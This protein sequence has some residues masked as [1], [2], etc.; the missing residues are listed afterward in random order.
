[1]T[2]SRRNFFKQVAAASGGA[3]LAELLASV[4]RASAI[5]PQPDSTYLDA[6]HVVILMQE[7]RS[8][9]HCFG[10]LRGVR[11]FNDPRAVKLPD[12]KP[13]W[14]QSNQAG[15]TYAPFRLN[16]KETKATWLGSL[17][18]SWSDQTDA[19]NHGN[20]D[21]W[22]D[23][24]V[25]GRREC[26]GMPFTMGYYER[27]D[28]PFYY[29]FADAFTIC[30]QHFCS[31][32][33]GTTPNRL[34][35]WTGTVREK[36]GATPCVRNSEADYGAPVRWKTFPERLEDAGVSWKIYQNELSVETGLNKEQEVWLANYTDNPIE[37]FEQFHVN[38]AENHR[39]ELEH[40][41]ATLPAEIE[42]MRKSV[43]AL[44]PG[45][46]D[47]RVRSRDLA[48][49]E[50][51][52]RNAIE[53]RAKWTPKA[54]AALTPADWSLHRKAFTTN[55]GDPSYRELEPL[56]YRDGNATRE[57]L[58]PKG[59]VLHQFRT[60]VEKG[61]LPTVSWL[62][63]P[64]N[65]SD[66]PAAPWYGAWYVAEA[67]DILTRNPEVW[68]KTI[69]ILTYDENDGY[70]DHVP[71]FV[72]PDPNNGE[73]GKTSPGMGAE[74]DYLTL[75]QDMARGKADKPRGG[76]IGLGYRVPLIVASP[77]S[78]GGYVCS[79]VFD[80]TSVLQLLEKVVTRRAGREIKETNISNWRRT[81]CGDLSAAFRPF[82]QSPSRVPFPAKN[83]FL[84]SVHK[85]QLQPMPSGF[86]KLSAADAE[87]FRKNRS[88]V[89]WMPRQEPGT[90]PSAALPYQLYAEGGL[91][92][93]GSR[94]DLALEAKNEI[95]GARSAGSPFHV[96]TS[97][98]FR[99]Q[100]SLRTRAY[101]V[102]AGSRVADA[103]AIEGFEG[104][105]YDL[106]VCGPN[107][108]YRSFAGSAADPKIDVR[109]EY[110]RDA[111]RPGTLTGDIELRATSR[112][113]AYTLHVADN[114]YGSDARTIQVAAGATE[115]IVMR[116]S[117]SFRWY[118]FSV[119]VA[120]AAGFARH[121]AGRVE[122]GEAGF[123][124]PAMG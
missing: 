89:A 4:Q 24:K 111:S 104:G 37:F 98:I 85:A 56:R 101:T 120:G 96:Y 19:R 16:M 3:G 2:T 23:A 43:A 65:F 107:G 44:P 97:G 39:R 31:T 45:S 5:E 70:F 108:F 78:R 72:A 12:G 14:M 49:K 93:D 61:Q 10:R 35:L 106:H 27:E 117:K 113:G 59:D 62:V 69:F 68:K 74:S 119:T 9:D 114:A 100:A 123:S 8:F 90:R 60:D 34:F 21:G 29:A 53:E 52:L 105:I 91:S 99:K 36:S 82:D 81:V 118:D 26:A 6:E 40:L 103:W 13:V 79:Q 57:M 58:I 7:N 17:P 76:P 75:E 28:I 92:A 95:F 88:A 18:H 55:Q 122:T 94:F 33:T 121:Y 102:A 77:W 20:H 1:M 11:G 112:G 25:S 84:E 46:P 109:C 30:D 80:H 87:Q 71:P 124:D 110:V 48:R 50:D 42:E 86:R 116:L 83:E 67:L 32:L 54:V 64:E 22:L 51:L 66:H 38:A 47:L 41:T 15:E 73:T 63:A 115:S